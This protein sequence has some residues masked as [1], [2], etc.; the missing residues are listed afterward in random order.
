MNG[1]AATLAAMTAPSAD[2]PPR[3]R[4]GRYLIEHEPYNGGVQRVTTF[5]GLLK[6]SYRLTAWAKRAVAQGVA[7]SDELAELVR[8]ATERNALDALCELAMQRA[9]ANDNRDRGTA[10]HAATEQA[11]RN[12]GE[13]DG[14]YGADVAAYR[15]ALDE[16]GLV[17]H[18]DLIEVCVAHAD[19]MVAGTADRFVEHPTFG[20]V[21]FDIKTGSVDRSGGDNAMQLHCYTSA[22]QRWNWETNTLAAMPD[23]NQDVGIVAHLPAGGP[24]TLHYVDLRQGREGCELALKLRDGWRKGRTFYAPVADG[25]PD[26]GKPKRKARKATA[27]KV[28]KVKALTVER[29]GE[30]VPELA[31]LSKL[32]RDAAQMVADTIGAAVAD[33]VAWAVDTPHGT[34]VLQALVALAKHVQDVD[35]ARAVV[36]DVIYKPDASFTDENLAT[37]KASNVERFTLAQLLNMAEPDD[38]VQITAVAN[39]AELAFAPTG[40]PYVKSYSYGHPD[41]R[42]HV[43]AALAPLL[44]ADKRAVAERWPAD[45]PPPKRADEWSDN[46]MQTIET[47]FGLPFWPIDHE[48]RKR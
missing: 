19:Y 10:V 25:V 3:D 33:D 15:T 36:A 14:P 17:V 8:N 35:L 4:F 11:D 2:G 13:Y 40:V 44:D 24:C 23:V 26:F 37:A 22:T 29:A 41:R 21:G 31:T 48:T 42:A 45:V 32:D 7:G 34:Q 16:Y 30:L 47:T 43:T 28:P 5:V 46:H 9:G 1:N 38:L 39:V 20:L 18:T 27:P 12:G 6:D